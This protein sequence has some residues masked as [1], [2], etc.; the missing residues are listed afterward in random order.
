MT[1]AVGRGQ[2]FHQVQQKWPGIRVGDQPIPGLDFV[3]GGRGRIRGNVDV[4]YEELNRRYSAIR[5]AQLP[6]GRG[7][8]TMTA[9]RSCGSG[10]TPVR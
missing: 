3:W 10:G 1:D 4:I 5:W 6:S 8:T 7:R 2:R 9:P